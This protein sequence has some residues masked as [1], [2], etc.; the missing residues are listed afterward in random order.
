MITEKPKVLFTDGEGPLV[1]KDLARDISRRVLG[2]ITFFDTLSMYNGFKAE[3]QSGPNEP[4]DTLALLV[5]HLLTSGITDEYLKRESQ[6]AALAPGVEG[7]L[8][9]LY[10]NGWRIL[11][12]STAYN[13]L[14]D[15]VGPKLGIPYADITSTRLNLESLREIWSEQSGIATRSLESF[16]IMNQESIEEAQE[17]YRRGESLEDLFTQNRAMIQ[18]RKAMDQLYQETLPG[19]G[20]NP[21]EAIKAINGREKAETVI[22]IAAEMRIKPEDIVYIG[23]SITD[24]RAIKCVR[25]NRGLAI[26]VNA[27]R[28]ALKN[29]TLGI[30]TQDMQALIPI[31]EGFSRG[32][33]EALRILVGNDGY[34]ASG[35]ERFTQFPEYKGPHYQLDPSSNL[36]RVAD[37]HREYSLAMRG[38]SMPLI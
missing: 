8:K 15:Y 20:F 1:F 11:V 23:D 29:A 5:P 22:R 7:Y 25:E 6:N 36:D 32:G 26:A 4:G 19:L 12:I 9:N 18:V 21:F 10:E 38:A 34:V 14:W 31:I 3:T 13:A 27:D 33:H 24:D 17:T 2:G 37:L 16:V 30:A 35:K 28:F